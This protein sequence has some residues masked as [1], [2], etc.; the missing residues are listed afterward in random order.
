MKTKPIVLKQLCK[1]IHKSGKLNNID[2]SNVK[3]IDDLIYIMVDYLNR[4]NHNKVD[5]NEWP[6]SEL[7]IWYAEVG[8]IVD[9][10]CATV[11][12]NRDLKKQTSNV[13]K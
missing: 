2:I 5:D 7:R 10:Y 6:R 12:K 1:R 9:L 3:R 4:A 13:H 8:Q 11:I